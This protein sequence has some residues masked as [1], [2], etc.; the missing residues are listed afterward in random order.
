MRVALRHM[1][2]LLGIVYPAIATGQVAPREE[3]PNQIPNRDQVTRPTPD[4][5]PERGAVSIK[6]TGAVERAPCPLET[7][8]V[9]ATIARIAFTGSGG[10]PLAPELVTLLQDVRA[11]GS[12]Q[13]IRV[14]CDIRDQA[15]A[16]LRRGRYVATVQVPPQR[17]EDGTLRLEVV[18]ARIVEMRV[19]GDPGPYEA[20]LLESI[21]QLKRLDP[22]NEAEAERILLLTGDVPGLDVQLALRPTGAKPG[23][24]IGEMTL[25]YRRFSLIANAQNYNSTQLGRETGYVRAEIYGL[26]GASDTTYF[27]YSSTVDFKEQMIW[28][29]GHVAGIDAQGTT[30]GSR[31]T[32]AISRPTLDRLSLETKSFIGSIEL[33]RPL[34]RSV[35]VN[36]GLVGGLEFSEQ[37]TVVGTAAGAVPLNLDR[38][39]AFFL[40]AS[41]D[42]RDFDRSGDER[43]RTAGFLEVRQ[44]VGIF[45]ATRTGQ[46][47]AGGFSPSRFE[48]SATA[49]VVRAQIDTRI[50]IGPIFDLAGMVRGQWS[51]RPL[52]NFDEFSAGNLTVG[53]GYDP[54]ANSGDRA[55]GASVELR[56]KIIN[57]PRLTIEPFGFYDAVRIWNLDR[58]S[59]ENNR[60]LRSWGGG[61]RAVLPGFAL[62]EVT[63]AKPLD[64][65]LSFDAAPPPARVLLSLTAQL[66]PFGGRR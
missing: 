39:T 20:R 15:N 12:E 55:I 43:T 16:L 66:V 28:Q 42:I 54:G 36:A 37:R 18:S 11:P 23:E 34:I 63:Y 5:R 27:G 2:P 22:L 64:R 19:R 46:V 62:L 33:A 53:R 51:N 32:Y 14:V 29:L 40:R 60:S 38:I 8:D 45:N 21:E 41:G 10:A 65:A 9:R 56:A 47:T 7:S 50:G 4:G 44:G 48:G 52:L 58:N 31:I 26:T 57:M 35:N 13:P 30:L 3:V 6:S 25:S 59:T 17:I 1:V 24:V 49:T 61:V